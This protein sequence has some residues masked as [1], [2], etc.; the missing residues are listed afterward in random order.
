MMVD[1]EVP[2]ARCSKYSAG[3]CCASNMSSSTGTSI[4]PPPMPNMPAKTPTN[5]PSRRYAKYQSMSAAHQLL[6]NE[7]P[8]VRIERGDGQAIAALQRAHPCQLG[9]PAQFIDG[10]ERYFPY[11]LHIHIEPARLFLRGLGIEVFS[12]A[13]ELRGVGIGD[14]ADFGDA[15]DA[16]FLAVGVIKQH[17]VADPHLVAHEVARL[18]VAHAVPSR[19]LTWHGGE[20]VDAAIARFGFH[21]PV[22]HGFIPLFL[23][24]K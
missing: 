5:A 24:Q 8:F 22:A 10:D 16:R 14:A 15:G 4:A 23:N 11:Q 20:I 21:Q 17:A 7:L 19:R 9:M 1:I 6:R 13:F 18:V 3:K 12:G 2:S